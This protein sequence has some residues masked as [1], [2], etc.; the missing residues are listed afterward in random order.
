M[1]DGTIK[2][3]TSVD[4][5]GINKAGP[6]VESS[7]KRM[8]SKIK[9]VFGL[10][11]TDK[12]MQKV[13]SLQKK[14]DDA[15][16]A[17]K[18]HEAEL[19]RLK[20]K[21]KELKTPQDSFVEPPEALPHIAQ[22]ERAREQLYKAKKELAKINSQPEPMGKNA[23]KRY[24]SEQKRWNKEVERLNEKYK[25]ILDK[26]ELIEIKSANVNERKRLAEIEAVNGKIRSVQ[27]ALFQSARNASFAKSSLAAAVDESKAQ[28]FTRS[29]KEATAQLKIFGTRFAGIIK[30]ALIFSV[31]YK[32]L[33]KTVDVISSMLNQNSRITSSLANI[34]GNLLTAF[35]PIY[36]YALPA[37]ESLLYAFEKASA[38]IAQFTSALFGRSVS[39]MQKNAQ[40]LNSQA[41]ATTN[42]GKAADKASRSLAKFD[43]LNRLGE[44]EKGTSAEKAE[45]SGP[46]FNSDIS[47][48]D[49]KAAKIATYGPLLLGTAL[50]IF[51]LATFN[52]PA[53][54]LG[55]LTVAAGLKIGENTST[56]EKNPPW[57]N[58]MITWGTSLVGVGLLIAGIV[59]GNVQMTLIGLSLVAVGLS[60][61]NASGAFDNIPPWVDQIIVWGGIIAGTAMLIAGIATAN[62]PLVITGLAAFGISA[63][64][65][66]HSGAFSDAWGAVKRFGSD[67]AKNFTTVYNNIKTGA[68]NTWASIKAWFSQ[69]VAPKFTVAYWKSKFDTMKEGARAAVNGIISIFER[70]INNIISRANTISWHVPDW[71][72]AIGGGVFGFNLPMVAMPR[73]ATGTVVPA[74]FGET[75]VIVGDNRREIEVISPLST[76][77]QALK[78][79]MDESGS[80]MELYV[81]LDSVPIFKQFVKWHNGE[82]I[83]KGKTP[84]KGT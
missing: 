39:Q 60:Y 2:F 25:S 61:G 41:K 67:V 42:A 62:I 23:M 24:A 38:F 43:E 37:I 14:Y 22:A 76:M 70:G 6:M 4:V 77:K 49:E 36:E 29:F 78:E 9:S 83:L 73:L 84:L 68:S 13:K 12:A 45:G 81:M 55:I 71:V 15:T 30:S 16:S 64:Y 59:I 21:L 56:L 54:L 50:L 7:L 58:Q 20:M 53:I 32:A 72:P 10:N 44:D 66:I 26:I 27:T 34:K 8:N 5:D 79:V 40:A 80:L 74:G 47:E 35:Q 52:L 11:D 51:G 57:L 31:L 1:S 69:N 19:G 46:S 3:D 18:E 33:Q 75:P 63:A 28:K 48:L 17:V 65:G 82:V